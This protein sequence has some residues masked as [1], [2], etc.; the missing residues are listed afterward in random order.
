MNASEW[1][2]CEPIEG[3]PALKF[4]C[5]IEIVGI[6]RT[7]IRYARDTQTHYATPW[8]RYTSHFAHTFQLFVTDWC[9]AGYVLSV[10]VAVQGENHLQFWTLQGQ[11]PTPQSIHDSCIT[12]DATLRDVQ[13]HHLP[14]PY[15]HMRILRA[16]FTFGKIAHGISCR[17]IC[18]NESAAVDLSR[19]CCQIKLQTL[20]ICM[21]FDCKYWVQRFYIPCGCWNTIS[22]IYG[23]SVW[24]CQM[25]ALVVSIKLSLQL[26]FAKAVCLIDWLRCACVSI[27]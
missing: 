4:R 18:E 20:F 11:S 19:R 27:I 21:F 10:G 13:T 14:M 26:S 15:A 7:Y 25:F 12:P 5:V 24:S 16:C 23:K 2:E 3:E 9:I 6:I 8:V 22:N 17:K 1:S